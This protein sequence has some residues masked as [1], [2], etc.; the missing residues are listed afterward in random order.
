LPVLVNALTLLHEDINDLLTIL[1]GNQDGLGGG[2]EAESGTDTVSLYHFNSGLRRL[3]QSLDASS[4]RTPCITADHFSVLDAHHVL[5]LLL[6]EISAY[7]KSMACPLENEHLHFI[8]SSHIHEGPCHFVKHVLVQRIELFKTVQD[9]GGSLIRFVR[10][11]GAKIN[12]SLLSYLGLIPLES[13]IP[14]FPIP[15]W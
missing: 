12:K 9:N 3:L 2:G 4:R 13:P 7:P 5:T 8:V 10:Q 14:L 6:F 1:G 15:L 11:N